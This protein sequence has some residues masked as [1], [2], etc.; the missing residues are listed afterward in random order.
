MKSTSQLP[1]TI[2]TLPISSNTST[3]SKRVSFDCDRPIA[4]IRNTSSVTVSNK[5]SSLPNTPALFPNSPFGTFDDCTTQ[6]S[7]SPD[8]HALDE[9]CSMGGA[10]KYDPGEVPQR[11]QHDHFSLAPST[12]PR[13]KHSS[14]PI[15]KGQRRFPS[16]DG[17]T[18]SA[19]HRSI[20]L[21]VC[22]SGNG[23]KGPDQGFAIPTRCKMVFH[24]RDEVSKN[25]PDE[26]NGLNEKRGDSAPQQQPRQY[27]RPLPLKK[28]GSNKSVKRV[29]FKEPEPWRETVA[30]VAAA[31]TDS[32]AERL[33]A[34]LSESELVPELE[35]NVSSAPLVTLTYTQPVQ[36]ST[37]SLVRSASVPLKPRT[38][39]TNQ[40]PP[41]KT[42]I[43]R[44]TTGHHDNLSLPLCTGLEVPDNQSQSNAKSKSGS[45]NKISRL[46]KNV[47]QRYSHGH[48]MRVDHGSGVMV[49][50][51]PFAVLA[52]E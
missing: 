19:A 38:Q 24:M 16:E 13:A 17:L 32:E 6:S 5:S 36:T 18:T 50:R 9:G 20:P 1:Q 8:N 37:D 30:T 31:D 43:L 40:T 45:G 2:P 22:L 35:N 10:L 44:S 51:E 34:V 3:G 23:Q 28:N 26:K 27:Q 4:N 15:L 33:L 7:L 47:A 46:W 48:G 39:F 14:M 49:G 42:T 52:R 29:S 21:S 12:H 25:K 11:T 41:V